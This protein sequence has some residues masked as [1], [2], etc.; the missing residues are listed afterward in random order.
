MADWW[1]PDE[2]RDEWRDAPASDVTLLR[3]IDVAKSEVLDFDKGATWRRDITNAGTP[4]PGGYGGDIGR[5][6]VPAGLLQATL[7]QIVNLW[8]ANKV[9]PSSGEIGDGSFV[10][11]A[12]PLDWAVRQ[13][14]RP[15]SPIGALG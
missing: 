8:N 4:W 15:Q 3:L 1:T 11:H 10:I 12:F 6:D 14:I 13:R 7:M 2:V 5:T 9:D